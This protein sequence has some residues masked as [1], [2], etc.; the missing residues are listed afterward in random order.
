MYKWNKT[1]ELWNLTLKYEKNLN[2]YQT[3]INHSHRAA[4][5]LFKIYVKQSIE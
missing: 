2:I 5:E 3:T 4:H 1:Q